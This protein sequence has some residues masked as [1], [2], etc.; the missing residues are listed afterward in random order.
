M[1][2]LKG[3]LAEAAREPNQ[4]FSDLCES[5]GSYTRGGPAHGF[6]IYAFKAS[7]AEG[8]G[9]ARDFCAGSEGVLYCLARFSA[10]NSARGASRGR[11]GRG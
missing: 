6:A 9:P 4:C 8:G 7:L 11:G 1:F 3:P 2:A 5:A 10:L